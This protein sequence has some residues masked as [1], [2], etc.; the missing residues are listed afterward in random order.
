MKRGV[1]AIAIG[2]GGLVLLFLLLFALAWAKSAHDMTRTIA[3]EDPGIAEL[4]ALAAPARARH[5]YVTRGCGDCHGEDGRGQPLFADPAI[6]LVAPNISPAG[7]GARYDADRI[8]AAIRHGVAADG[9]PLL[10]MPSTDWDEMSDEDTAAIVAHVL[11]LPPVEHDPGRTTVRPLGRVLY[12]LGLFPLLPALDIDHEP[13]PRRAPRAAATPQYGFYVAQT[14]TGC[15]GQDFRGLR[16]GP[17]GT[18]RSSDLRP[19]AA[20]AGWEEA[21]FVRAMREGRRP[22]GSELHPFMPWHTL[23]QMD[24][25]ELGALWKYFETL[26]PAG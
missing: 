24:D 14:C 16:H 15:H 25:V 10:F 26:P 2:A 13:R 23:G 7:L 19:G 3:V 9:R 11:A 8:A 6:E 17:P 18:P 21:D 20:M 5:L 22:D 12:L 4:V 1:R